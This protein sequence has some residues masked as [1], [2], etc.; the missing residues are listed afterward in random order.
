MVDYVCHLPFRGEFGYYLLAFVK[1]FHGDQNRNKIICLKHGHECL[2]PTAQEFYY[3][4][5]DISD[6]KKAGVILMDDEEEIKIKVQQKYPNDN[7]VFVSSKEIGW[8]NFH[9]FA[10]HSFIPQ[11]KTNN[12]LKTDIIIAP[13]NRK[14]D[15]FRNWTQENWQYVINKIIELGFT[16]GLCGSKE[17]SFD[18]ENTTYKSYNYLDVDSDVEMMLNSQLV[19]CQESGMQYLSF[20]CKRPTICIDYYG[21]VDRQQSLHRDPNAQHKTAPYVWSNPQLLVDEILYFLNNKTFKKSS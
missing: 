15:S 8:H 11:N 17:S 21:S 5:Q 4:W 19:V 14:V 6:E 10:T 12:N 1:R 2:F 16:V 7:I 20:L 3:D 18:L 13:R 9:S